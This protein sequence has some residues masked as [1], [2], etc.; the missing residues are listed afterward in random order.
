MTSNNNIILC[1]N[2]DKHWEQTNQEAG[3]DD[4]RDGRHKDQIINQA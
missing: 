3:L 2:N 4:H 1:I